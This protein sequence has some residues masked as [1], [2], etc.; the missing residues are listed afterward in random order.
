MSL[1]SIASVCTRVSLVM[2][3]AF[4][5]V[6]S[7]TPAKAQ[8]RFVGRPVAANQ[9]VSFDA[10]DHGVWNQLLQ[11][12][13]D[14]DG[15]V[16]YKAWKADTKSTTALDGYI[17]LLSTGDSGKPAS[18]E[19][20]LAY[21]IN[22][23]NAVT[24]KGILHE[25]PTKSIRNHTAKLWGY[26]IWKNLKLHTSG[27]K[28]NLNDIEHEVLRKMKE[29]RIHFAIVCASIGCPRLFNEAYVPQRLEEQLVTN[30]RDFFSRRQ[31]FQV[32]GST[33]KLSSILDWFGSDFGSDQAAQLRAISPYVPSSA[34][35]ALKQRGVRVSYLDYD[36]G[37]N[38]QK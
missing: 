30:T 8:D 4:L 28:I 10:I 31:N 5:L 2:A 18:R 34:Q 33:I 35:A 38:E 25:Y 19:A 20:T 37:I 15:L 14:K 9:R 6:A 12:Y 24:I 36:W 17:N 26:N 23:Y 16:N 7:A 32:S 11:K 13:V 21:W 3:P 1:C 29:P 27:T 22:A